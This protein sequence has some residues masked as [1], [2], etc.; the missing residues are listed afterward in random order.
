MAPRPHRASGLQASGCFAGTAARDT[1]LSLRQLLTDTFDAPRS[2]IT[3][4]IQTSKDPR[5][6]VGLGS[7]VASRLG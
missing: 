4:L 3:A 5:G 6:M 1:F 7:F 2:V